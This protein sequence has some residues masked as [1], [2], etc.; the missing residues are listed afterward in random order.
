LRNLKALYKKVMK[1]GKWAI[2]MAFRLQPEVPAYHLAIIQMKGKLLDRQQPVNSSNSNKIK[3]VD[4]P[5][6]IRPQVRRVR[7]LLVVQTLS[8]MDRMEIQALMRVQEMQGQEMQMPVERQVQEI[9]GW[10]W[11]QHWCQQ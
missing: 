7:S 4:H 8:A 11:L 1:R 10:H 2:L 5:L 9:Q 3:L 6:R